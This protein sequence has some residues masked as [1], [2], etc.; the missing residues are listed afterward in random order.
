MAG[1]STALISL[2]PHAPNFRQLTS[3]PHRAARGS[4]HHQ[5]G[6]PA[7]SAAPAAPQGPDGEDLGCQVLRVL[8]HLLGPRPQLVQ[9]HRQSDHLRRARPA[10]AYSD[11][12]LQGPPFEVVKPL[13]VGS[14][15]TVA[16]A[17]AG[18]PNTRLAARPLVR[19]SSHR[20]APFPTGR[21]CAAARSM[22]H[23][24]RPWRRRLPNDDTI[25][26]VRW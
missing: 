23:G 14:S 18:T 5:H 15:P 1:R 9:A 2:S 17:S 10:E 26:D 8:R 19:F 20:F 16:V 6:Q 24:H 3:P 4:L 11:E 21:L 22:D 25:L 13:M 7:P 12:G